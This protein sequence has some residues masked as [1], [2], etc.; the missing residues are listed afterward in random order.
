MNWSLLSRVTLVAAIIFGLLTLWPGLKC[1][2]Q[3]MNGTQL[4]GL[5]SDSDFNDWA[6]GTGSSAETSDVARVQA[7]GG[8]VN[9]MTSRA[10]TCIMLSVRN[11]QTW[12]KYG[13][14]GLFAMAF[15]MSFIGR[16]EYKRRIRKNA[17][18][19]G[20][21]SYH[22][23][24]TQ[25]AALK[26]PGS[27]RGLR[28][29]NAPTTSGNQTAV[30]TRPATS[31]SSG[32]L[33][34]PMSD[35]KY[36]GSNPVVG[37]E[38]RRQTA[39]INVPHV[40][41]P[42]SSGKARPTAAFSIDDDW[43]DTDDDLGG[44][45]ANSFADPSQVNDDPS[46][47]TQLRAPPVRSA[48]A[49]HPAPP[50]PEPAAIP[51]FDGPM[52]DPMSDGHFTTSGS[53][54]AAK[55]GAHST[56]VVAS[57]GAIHGRNAELSA[58]KLP[59]FSRIGGA[60]EIAL[61]FSEPPG[62]S[63]DRVLFSGVVAGPEGL[64][65][66]PFTFRAND[67]GD[68]SALR[69][70]GRGRTQLPSRFWTKDL[71]DH[72]TNTSGTWHLEITASLDGEEQYASTE[73]AD[74]L[75]LYLADPDGQPL[76]NMLAILHCSD[77]S[78][79][80]AS[81]GTDKPGYLR[82]SPVPIAHFDIEMEDDLRIY[83]ANGKRTRRARVLPDGM[84]AV[85]AGLDLQTAGTREIIIATPIIRYVTAGAS[86]DGSEDSPMGNLMH[87]VTDADNKRR[88]AGKRRPIEIRIGADGV[89]PRERAGIVDGAKGE[90]LKWWSGAAANVRSPWTV[91]LATL[92]T[93]PASHRFGIGLEGG[94]H[95]EGIEDLRI[96][97]RAFVELR[98]KA[99]IEP[100][101]SEHLDQ[102]FGALP[103][104]VFSTPES[105][106]PFQWRFT[107]CTGIRLEGLHFMG[108]PGLSG[109]SIE[110][111]QEVLIS[112]CWFER[113][114]SG[115][116]ANP[117]TRAA[118]RALHVRSSGTERWQVEIVECDIGWNSVLRPTMPVRAAAILAEESWVVL[119]RCFIHDNIAT[120]TPADLASTGSG[121]I[122]G[123]AT[124]H[125]VGNLI[126]EA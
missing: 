25:N 46:A 72:L 82:V 34:D 52:V 4:Q 33:Y 86:G 120:D 50:T 101:L 80:R 42:Q 29:I 48:P 7:A 102:L 64:Q 6:Y 121:R 56:A 99:A 47:P 11:A 27:S 37:T 43:G 13:S 51:F 61:A 16:Q 79:I 62:D 32:P 75:T 70:R 87:A 107:N 95:F 17:R 81:V 26:K 96:V 19:R 109:V 57:A 63:L 77:G 39:G 90:W 84:D 36:S 68:T 28:T 111:C 106:S 88:A 5:S 30:R 49:P 9:A 91:D 78:S 108:R 65:L 124:N 54:R 14:V 10:P 83:A 114:G 85:R 12:K 44:I 122:A 53:H 66:P 2:Y 92:H 73:L 23:A 113:F 100:E 35:P 94:W 126:I 97:N 117:S 110:G 76:S 60:L 89:S 22:T 93:D 118:G 125:A 115:P 69:S 104:A 41:K 59:G 18:E 58:I 45:L 119:T 71:A 67:L 21:G 112:R 103:Q 38:T 98:R 55:S 40:D 74:S 3:A 116:T 123:D 8:F 31:S 20:S 15:L 24:G 1:S 105:A